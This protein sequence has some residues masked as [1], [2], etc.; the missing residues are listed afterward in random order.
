[1]VGQAVPRKEVE[2]KVTGRAK[3]VD[4]LRLPD[5]LHGATVRSPVARGRITGVHFGLG[6]PW[7]EF[8]IVRASDIPGSNCISL[9]LDDQPC[10]A[11]G[12]VNHPEEPVLLLAH[13]DK[14]AL[15]RALAA[16][17]IEYEALPAI[18]TI[19]PSGARLPF[20]PTTPPVLSKGLSAE[21]T[22]S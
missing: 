12:V 14:H 18:F 3:Y 7:D 20:S 16:V 9:I 4:D 19:A 13:A 6:I 15:P 5:M 21:R 17:E 2:E 10:L 11:D 8:T 22:T 1:M